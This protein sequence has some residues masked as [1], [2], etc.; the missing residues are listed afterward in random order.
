MTFW[1]GDIKTFRGVKYVEV[2]AK[3]PARKAPEGGELQPVTVFRRGEE[4]V[5]NG[6]PYVQLLPV[7]SYVCH[8]CPQE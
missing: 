5:R 4:I 6:Q 3:E 2:C 8:C 7:L 1:S